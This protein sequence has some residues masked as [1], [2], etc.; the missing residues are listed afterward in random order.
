MQEFHKEYASKDAELYQKDMELLEYD[1][2]YGNQYT[3]SNGLTA[4]EP[5][6]M[7]MG[8]D[9]ISLT[10][11]KKDAN[12]EKTYIVTGENFNEYTTVFVNDKQVSTEFIDDH[13]VKVTDVSLND[14][15][16]VSS[17]QVGDDH[18]PLAFTNELLVQS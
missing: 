12:K 4:Y 17:A 6:D 2:L 5:T 9:K 11:I 14:G 16:R 1:L 13:Q 8:I 3:Y 15:D 7:Q 10:S 18:I